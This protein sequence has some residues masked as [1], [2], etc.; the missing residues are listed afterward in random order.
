MILYFIIIIIS[1]QFH[2]LYCI[3][4]VYI[5]LLLLFCCSVI[6]IKLL[7]MGGWLDWVI[8][9]VFSNL[10]DS[11]IIFCFIIFSCISSI[12]C[13]SSSEALEQIAQRGGGCS[14]P[15]DIHGQAGL[16]SE[17]PNLAVGGPILCRGLE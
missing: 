7:V 2:M 12:W 3:F 15:G 17:Q 13:S 5:V 6:I 10:G 14:I 9:W 4:S 16:G 11:M 1:S 8:L